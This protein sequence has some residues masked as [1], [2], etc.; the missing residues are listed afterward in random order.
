MAL[1]PISAVMLA[2]AK[3][4]AEKAKGAMP[5]LEDDET[6]VSENYKDGIYTRR[7]TKGEYHYDFRKRA[8][9]E[10]GV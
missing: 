7:T 5:D 8:L 1:S 10:G 9:V 2:V 4:L 6:I 3:E